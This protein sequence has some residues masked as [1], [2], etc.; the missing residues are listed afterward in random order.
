M[1]QITIHMSSDTKCVDKFSMANEVRNTVVEKLQ[2]DKTIGQVM[3]YET[4][5]TS[6]SIHESKNAK[7]I[8]VEIRMYPGREL[9]IKQNLMKAVVSVIH[10]YTNIEIKDITCSISE[11]PKDNYYTGA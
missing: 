7:F 8:F 6:R 4:P 10:K 9:Q 2:I 3:I 11:V 5:I 1:P